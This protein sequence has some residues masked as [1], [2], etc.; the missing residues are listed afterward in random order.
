M[1]NFSA[2]PKVEETEITLIGTGG[3]YGE[4]VVIKIG[5][6]DWIVVDSCLDPMSKKSLA[7]DYLESIS[8]DIE[9]DVR[10]VLCTHWH[11][12]HI[13]GISQLLDLAKNAT[14]VMA[15]IN[16]RQKFLSLVSLDY[17][18]FDKSSNSTTLEFNK[19]L[20]ILTKRQMSTKSAI[21]D[22]LIYKSHFDNKTFEVF[23]LS[24]SD[25]TIHEFDLEI[26]T[27]ITEFGE[28]SNKRIIINS[29]ND[30]SVALYLKIGNERVL[31]GSDLEVGNNNEK[32]WL[33][34]L[35]NSQSIDS[36]KSSLFKIPH[37]GSQNGYHKDIWTNLLNPNPIS[38]ITPWN[39]GKGLPSEDMLKIY[40]THTEN[41]YIT[42][43]NST[44]KS[45]KRDSLDPSINKF[46][47]S[48]RPSLEEIK[49]KHGMIRS[50]INHSDSV[51]TWLTETFGAAS[52]I[53]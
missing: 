32:G 39:R 41:L 13:L 7:T 28:N 3:G 46:I 42:S 50:R 9:N 2:P 21:C 48:V 20:E 24:P 10:V 6:K 11:D 36:T 35:R 52:S 37:H 12:D 8:V 16:D 15:K 45:K 44:P 4:C 27:L 23:S 38:K 22:R 51:P 5:K 17:Q 31:L 33:H 14:F 34:I 25:L 40:K 18:K 30:K 1:V 19:C 26:S 29:P 49:Y 53:N 47:K 43:D